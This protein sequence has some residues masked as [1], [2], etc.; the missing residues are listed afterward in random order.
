MVKNVEPKQPETPSPAAP[1]KPQPAPLVRKE[2]PASATAQKAPPVKPAVKAVKTREFVIQ[3][4]SFASR[5]KAEQAARTL[6]EKGLT[7]VINSRTTNESQFYRLRL[8]PYAT[9]GEAEKFLEWVKSVQGFQDS[10]IFETSA[11][12]P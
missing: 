11:A 8:G 1:L 10:M 2:S 4:G 3:V 5:D 9:R 7:G 6:K 12:K